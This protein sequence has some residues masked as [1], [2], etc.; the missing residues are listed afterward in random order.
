MNKLIAFPETFTYRKFLRLC[1]SSLSANLRKY[2]KSNSTQ[3]NEWW[4]GRQLN[5]H[6]KVVGYLDPVAL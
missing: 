5:I 3:W 4:L 6:V 1:A 2:G